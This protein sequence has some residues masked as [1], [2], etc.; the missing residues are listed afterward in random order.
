[1]MKKHLSWQLISLEK[2][3]AFLLLIMTMSGCRPMIAGL[4]VI[5]SIDGPPFFMKF[6]LDPESRKK[7]KLIVLR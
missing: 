2:S 7:M 4:D 3:L 5:T 6:Q 1:M